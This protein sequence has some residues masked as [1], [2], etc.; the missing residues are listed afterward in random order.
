MI[1][2]SVTFVHLVPVDILLIEFSK[3]NFHFVCVLLGAG[4]SR[5]GDV[6][7]AVRSRQYPPVIDKRPAAE[8][9]VV[10]S[11]LEPS[12][13]RPLL[14]RRGNQPANDPL[15]FLVPADSALQRTGLWW[16]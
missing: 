8:D 1:G 16:M 13:P 3:N 11:L 14:V 2:W 15:V 4:F 5:F 6:F 9:L 10:P 7:D 12:L